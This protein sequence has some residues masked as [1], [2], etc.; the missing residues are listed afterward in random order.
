MKINLGCGTDYREGFINVD[1]NKT[2][3]RIDKIINIPSESLLSHFQESPVGYVLANDII[4]HL[5]HWE[6]IDIL[7]QIYNILYIGGIVEIR[8]P[9]AEYIINSWRLSL[10]KKLNL[11]FGGQDIPQ[12]VNYEMDKSR[13]EHPHLFCHKYGWTKKSIYAEL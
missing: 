3:T 11:L 5:F 12:G 8:A 2:L 10:E 1:G 4:E 9:D 6:A 7:R 13:K